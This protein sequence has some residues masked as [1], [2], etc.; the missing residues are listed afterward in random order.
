MQREVAV[1][2]QEAVQKHAAL[3]QKSRL[4]DQSSAPGQLP[5]GCVTESLPAAAADIR[6]AAE[7]QFPPA[8][9]NES[10]QISLQVQPPSAAM[11]ESFKVLLQESN[12]T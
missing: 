1:V 6:A 10:F 4:L 12:P 8:A 11:N 9:M 2:T 5:A 7:S 3:E